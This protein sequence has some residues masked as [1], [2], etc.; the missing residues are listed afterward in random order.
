LVESVF[1]EPVEVDAENIAERSTP[2]PIRHG[3]FG[4]WRDQSIEGH[5]TRKLTHGLGQPAVAQN[6]VEFEPLPELIA[7][8]HGSGL[9]VALRGD[10]TGINLDQFAAGDWCGGLLGHAVGFAF[11]PLPDPANDIGHFS[12][13]R[14]EQIGLADDGVFDLARK[15]E[16]VRARSRAQIAQGTHRPLARPFRGSERLHQ[17][18]IGIGPAFIGANR[19]ADVHAT[20]NHASQKNPV[21]ST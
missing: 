5:R 20:T 9:T 12:I 11:A 1:R 6:A 17:Y 7:H 15:L 2:D 4:A 13:S 16:P 8:M 14:I 21:K 10:A 3:M 19:F 18:V